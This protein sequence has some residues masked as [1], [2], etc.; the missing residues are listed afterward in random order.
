M[1]LSGA[2]KAIRASVFADLAPRIAA[3]TAR[4]GHL[5]PLHI[6]DTYRPPPP[7]GRFGAPGPGARGLEDEDLYRYGAITGDPCL[8][9]AVV[10]SMGRKAAADGGRLAG[11][12]ARNVL[13]TVGATHGLFCAAR[14]VLDPGDEVVVPA[15]YWPLSVGVFHACSALP[16]EVRREGDWIERAITPRTRAF[17]LTTPNNPDGWVASDDELARVAAVACRHGLWVFA[18]EVYA[19]YVYEGRH[20]SIATLEGMAERTLTVTSF[21]KSHALAGAR[22]GV[23]VGPEAAVSAARRVATHTAFNVPVIAQRAAARAL[24]SGDRWIDE[25]RDAYVVARSA[26]EDALRGAPVVLRPAAGGSYVFLDLAP[27]LRGRT[28]TSLLERAIDA[29]VLLAPGEAFG[30]GFE[31]WARLCFTAVPPAGLDEALGRLRRVLD[32]R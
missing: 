7:E 4:G 18:D 17:Y 16:K 26:T 27:A 2:A 3:F 23:L 8:L 24:S 29:G 19:D 28:L 6:G 1:V 32:D 15:P 22:V 10:A 30:A 5:F 21:S 11:V 31:T 14:A 9:E 25:A 13:I 20:R 12:D